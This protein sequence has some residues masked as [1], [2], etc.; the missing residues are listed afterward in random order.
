MRNGNGT[1]HCIVLVWGL[2]FQGCFSFP[3][4]QIIRVLDPLQS[5]VAQVGPPKIFLLPQYLPVSICVN[6]QG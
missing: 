5:K 4:R 1:P 2:N 3:E 6:D